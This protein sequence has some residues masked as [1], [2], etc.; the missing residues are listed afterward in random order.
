[1]AL[2]SRRRLGRLPGP[3]GVAQTWSGAAAPAEPRVSRPLPPKLLPCTS[4]PSPAGPYRRGEPELLRVV[5][6]RA[7]GVPMHPGQLS[8]SRTSGGRQGSKLPL[9]WPLLRAT[10][11]TVQ[12]V[13]MPL[14]V[15][16]LRRPPPTRRSS[17]VAAAICGTQ[18]CRSVLSASA[19]LGLLA[20]GCSFLFPNFS[21]LESGV[22]DSVPPPPRNRNK[23]LNHLGKPGRGRCVCKRGFPRASRAVPLPPPT[24]GSR[25]QGRRRCWA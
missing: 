5:G 2:R 19:S 8:H 1:M 25:C 21:K 6:M 12:T 4:P 14:P 20:P 18:R 3:P 11:V 23:C 22:S 24:L 17:P 13:K 7:C 9:P 10:R 16:L 15:W